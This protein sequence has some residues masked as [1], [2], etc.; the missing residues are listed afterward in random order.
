MKRVLLL[1]ALFA[2]PPLPAFA[3]SNAAINLHTATVAGFR[4]GM[5]VP[6]ALAVI[7]PRYG[8]D[9]Q[10]FYTICIRDLGRS[11]QSHRD[12]PQHCVDQIRATSQGTS[13]TLS[14]VE[15]FSKPGMSRLW[16][17]RMSLPTPQTPVDIAHFREQ[18]L[19]RY[20]SPS[21][22]VGTYPNDETHV[23]MAY[24]DGF[25]ADSLHGFSQC[26]VGPN[27]MGSNVSG[28]QL[29]ELVNC[30]AT[31]VSPHQALQVTASMGF[32]E[33]IVLDD[34]E[35]ECAQ[36]AA[37]EKYLSSLSTGATSF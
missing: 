30:A 6:Q 31:N 36:G 26:A 10:I 8:H 22:T 5:T 27:T 32:F 37:M 35:Y 2:I 28:P 11:M 20:G 7:K 18:V 33:S 21:T 12:A 24:C 3:D 15:D 29:P 16:D 19:S 17:I 14:F 1:A 25:I 34:Y 4:L 9:Y 23:F 13:L